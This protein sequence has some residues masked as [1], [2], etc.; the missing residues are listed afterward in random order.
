MGT[1]NDYMLAEA[2]NQTFQAAKLSDLY[3]I[4]KRDQ[5][6]LQRVVLGSMH[7]HALGIDPTI[8]PLESQVDMPSGGVDNST[9]TTAQAPPAVYTILVDKQLSN[10]IPKGYQLVHVTIVNR[11][12]HEMT[13]TLGVS[14]GGI[15]L[16]DGETLAPGAWFDIPVEKI[17]SM[18]EDT[19]LFISA[20]GGY[21]SGLLMIVETKLYYSI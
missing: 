21:T 12:S 20:A 19:S 11:E 4:G 15:D 16:L 14:N 6:L 9:T 5:K 18:T 7:L 10:V 13:L 2:T 17:Y 8:A 1:F 3:L